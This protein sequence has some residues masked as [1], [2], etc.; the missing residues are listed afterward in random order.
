VH[1]VPR[2]ASGAPRSH[3]ASTM[4]RSG[5]RRVAAVRGRAGRPARRRS[6][7]VAMTGYVQACVHLRRMVPQELQP[8]HQLFNLSCQLVEGCRV[9]G[10]LCPHDH[11]Q[12]QRKRQESS[13]H[14]LSQPSLHGIPP[15]CRIAVAR[16]HDPGA[17]SRMRG[18]ARPNQECMR[19]ES[20][21]LGSDA[22]EVDA[23]HASGV[24]RARIGIA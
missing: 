5:M 12:R 15:H 4:G 8:S 13:P 6:V 3:T 22:L 2:R 19:S 16:H 18:S 21:P 11:V 23:R 10:A 24:P 14:E 7:R 17:Q 9:G 20:L 1:H